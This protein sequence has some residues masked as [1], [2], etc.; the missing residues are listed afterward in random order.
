MAVFTT[1]NAQFV[2][3][4]ELTEHLDTL[5]ART[6]DLM[7]AWV[8]F[9]MPIALKT[10]FA[11]FWLVDLG[12][13]KEFLDSLNALYASCADMLSEEHRVTF[14]ESSM[15]AVIGHY[16]VGLATHAKT[17]KAKHTQLS[18]RVKTD[19]ESMIHLPAVETLS[20]CTR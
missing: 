17:L 8:K 10:L 6:I 13:S 3:K 15:K 19:L 4:M 11:Q 16:F 18:S 12:K 14:V 1:N 2:K 5:A 9:F 20:K 7:V